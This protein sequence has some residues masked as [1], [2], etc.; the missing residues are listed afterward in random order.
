MRLNILIP[1]NNGAMAKSRLWAITY[2][3][4]IAQD[5]NQVTVGIGARQAG[6]VLEFEALKLLQNGT[7]AIDDVSFKNCATGKKT[8]NDN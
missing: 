4:S 1:D 5:W 7:M 8:T 2:T 6:F 3:S